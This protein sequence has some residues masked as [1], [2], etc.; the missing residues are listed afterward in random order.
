VARVAGTD[1]LVYLH[2]EAIATNDDVERAEVVAGEGG[3]FSIAVRFTP[4]GAQ[5][6]ERATSAAVGKRLAVLI[7]GQV[8]ADPVVRG[9]I[10]ASGVLT[11]N[12]SRADADKIAAG[13]PR[14]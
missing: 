10:G 1:R 12:F 7:D 14:K 2:P 11:G 8:V 4:S 13:I 3:R 6:M 9:P 5:K